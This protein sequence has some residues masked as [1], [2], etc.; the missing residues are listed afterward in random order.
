METMA[1][2]WIEEGKEIGINIGE[3]RG[4]QIGEPEAA[5]LPSEKP[6]YN[7]CNFASQSPLKKKKA[8]NILPTLPKLTTST[9]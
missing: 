3:A 1:Q 8:K 5:Y 9:T 2:E 7:C 4:V 6:C